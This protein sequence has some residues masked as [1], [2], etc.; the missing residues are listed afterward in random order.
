MKTNLYIPEKIVVGFQERSD[1]F[2]GKLAYVIYKDHTGKLRKEASWNGWRNKK[3]E[4]VEVDNNPQSGFTFNKGVQRDNYYFGTGR[5]MI[6][7]YDPRDFEFEVTVDNLVGLLMHSDVSKRDIV[8]QCVYAWAGTELVLL[9]V[10]SREYQESVQH[11]T[12]QKE[13]VSAKSLVPGYTYSIKKENDTRVVYLGRFDRY[14]V[15]SE[16]GSDNGRYARSRSLQKKK[17]KGHVFYVLDSNEYGSPI[18]VKD[19]T[20]YLAYCELEEVHPNFASMLDRYWTSSD[21]QPAV[22]LAVQH[23]PQRYGYGGSCWYQLSDNEFIEFR[24]HEPQSYGSMKA[25]HVTISHFAEFNSEQPSVEYSIEP[26]DGGWAYNYRRHPGRDIGTMRHDRTDIASIRA[27]LSL[28]LAEA[29]A[30]PPEGEFKSTW[31][32]DRELLKQFQ[33]KHKL[34]QLCFKLQDGKV[35]VDNSL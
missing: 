11:T 20:Q 23:I 18:V 31:E 34:G 16:Y 7:V 19:P 9:P 8:E 30:N 33:Q 13:K 10:N 29:Y 35:C 17:T 12:K 32:R 26:Y 27:Q 22:G 24:L 15:E 3:F 4:P 21:A 25:A 6:R 2:T 5:S 14:K 28:A 1:T